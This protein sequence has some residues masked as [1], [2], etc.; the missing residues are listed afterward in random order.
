MAKALKTIRNLAGDTPIDAAL[1]LGSGLSDIGD[2]LTDKVTIPF[3]DLKGFPQGGV[4]G[5]GKDLL[6]GQMGSRR[7][8]ILTGRQHYY[9]HGD[10]AAM[11]PALETLAELGAKTL[12]LTNSAGSLDHDVPPGN[13]MLLSDHINYAGV[14][15]L[16]GED[17]DAR[18]VNMVDAYDPEL[19]AT[20]HAV[21]ARLEIALKE[22]IYMWYSG[23]SFETP[24]EIRMAR[25]LGADAVGMSTVPEVIVAR[26][27]GLR[28]AACSVITNLAAGMTGSELSHDETKEMA[29]LGG[30]RLATILKTMFAD[31][32]V[33]G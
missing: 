21:A 14:N 29:P 24:A 9:E 5:H 11:R 27:L 32:L 18:F 23:P 25:V 17:T 20:T 13:L 4:S 1:I 22:G 33:D 30:Q 2:L 6:I 31:G 3:S 10:P 28:V 12:L 8:A 7:L 19:R 26:F 15:P 16:I